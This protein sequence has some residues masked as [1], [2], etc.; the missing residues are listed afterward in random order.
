MGVPRDPAA[1]LLSSLAME[2]MGVTI[3]TIVSDNVAAR[4]DGCREV[5][6]LYDDESSETIKL[7][8]ARARKL[9]ESVPK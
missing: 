7:N 6:A 2:I 4:C 5:I 8:V 1:A 9:L 3:R